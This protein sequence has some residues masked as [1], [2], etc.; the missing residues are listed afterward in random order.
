LTYIQLIFVTLLIFIRIEKFSQKASYKYNTELCTFD[1]IFD[2]TK[3][4]RT[5]L[6]NTFIYLWNSPYI[7]T[8]ANAWT[9]KQANELCIEKLNVECFKR[10]EE[11]NTL[12]FI[13]TS[14][15]TR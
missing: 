3:Y 8:N 14:C 10:L 15:G 11:L 2:S 9:L 4:A 7:L 1:V 12:D 13:I 5:Q 6:Q